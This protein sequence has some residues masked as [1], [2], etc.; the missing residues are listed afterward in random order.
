MDDQYKL[1]EALTKAYEFL[2]FTSRDVNLEQAAMI[3]IANSL[4]AIAMGLNDDA[5]LVKEEHEDGG[6]KKKVR[7]YVQWIRNS[8]FNPKDVLTTVI[9]ILAAR[10]VISEFDR[11]LIP[12]WVAALA[13]VDPEK[14]TKDISEDIIKL[15]WEDI[16]KLV[17]AEEEE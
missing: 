11:D 17:W 2:P 5:R 14:V 15:V 8:L 3:S 13:G 7:S 6:M 12:D 1:S 10:Y 16:I 4:Y 9:L